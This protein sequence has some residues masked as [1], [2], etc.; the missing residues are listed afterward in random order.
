MSTEVMSGSATSPHQPPMSRS[1]SKPK[2]ILKNA[3]PA[4]PN[5]QHLQWDEENLALTEA[6]KDS[7]MKITEPKTPYVRYNA[8]TD[9][10]EGDIPTLDLNARTT[11]PTVLSPERAASPTSSTGATGGGSAPSSRRTSFSSTGRTSTPSGRPGSGRSSRSTSFNLPDAARETIRMD[12]RQPGD[13]IEFEE[14][15]EETAAKHAAFVRARGRHYSNE[16][17]AMKLAAKLMEQDDDEDEEIAS[18]AHSIDEDSLMS[19]DEEVPAKMN[20]VIHGGN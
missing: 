4:H 5:P 17:E 10:V 15:D 8:E 6:Q 9:T 18:V 11:S 3:P 12:D 2:G 16:A 19:T 20:G 13:E 1:N 14:M 7:Q